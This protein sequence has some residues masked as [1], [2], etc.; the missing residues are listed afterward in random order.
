MV[1]RQNPRR[2]RT[3]AKTAEIL[4]KEGGSFADPH[5]ILERASNDDLD[6]YDPEELAVVARHAREEIDAFDGGESRITVRSRD[7]L[8]IGGE[9]VS[10]VSV[11]GRDMPFLFDSIMAEVTTGHRD[12]PLAIHPI[13]T[14]DA[15]GTP[16]RAEAG[17][18]RKHISH[19]QIH[20]PEIGETAAERLVERL[21]GVLDQVHAAVDDWAAMLE[22]LDET[23]TGLADHASEDGSERGEA[24]AFLDWLRDDNFIF[25]GMR[26][27][28]YVTDPDGAH[29]ERESDSGLGILAD[30]DIRV[31][32]RGAD[33]VTTTPEI[34]AFLEGSGLLIVTKANARSVVHRRAYMDY[35]G[36]KRFDGDG[37]LSGELRVVGLFTST[38]YTRPLDEIPL[39]RTKAKAVIERFHFDPHAHSGKVL[40][41]TLAAYPRDELF[42]IDTDLLAAFCEQINELGERPRVRVLPRIDHF[43]RFVSV[44]VFVPRERYD[45]DVRGRIGTCLATA[46]GGHVSAFYPAFPEGAVARVH[47]IIG[48]HDGATPDVSQAHLEREVRT[49]VTGWD[50]RFESLRPTGSAR[51][52]VDDAYREVFTPEEAVAD[53]PLISAATDG[54][55]IHLAFHRRRNDVE[56]GLS[57]K[58]FHTGEAL[59]LSRRVPLLENLGFDVV[60]ER[61]FDMTVEDDGEGRAVVL[62]DMQL[63]TMDGEPVD[64]GASETALEEAFL[65]IWAGR[66]DND[67]FN[68]L[69]VDAGLD[70]RKAS[71]LR[72]YARYL[73]Q[74][75]IT[76][77]QSYMAGALDRYP[78]AA[79]DIFRLF[80]NR[81]DPALSERQRSSRDRAIGERIDG[82]LAKVPSLDDDRIL[83]RFVN[84]V[85]ASL[86]TNYFQTGADGESPAMLAFKLDPQALEDLPQP[87]PYREI[88][89]Y[90]AEV[91]GVHLRFGPIARGGIRWSDRAE[92]YRTEV[93]GL[94]KA[95]QVKNAVI[96]PVGAKG[97][98]YP[99]QL[100]TGDRDAI[101]QAGK[102]A[103][104]TYITTLLSITD[105]IS[106]QEIVPPAD[107]VCHEGDDPYFVVAA[108]KGTATFSD[109]ANAI[110]Q[111]HDFWLDDAFASGGSAGYDHKAMA[112]T[113]RGA[114]EA[115]KRHFREM[116]VDIQTTPF[117]VAGVGDMSGDVF[118]NGM[119]LSQQI[120]LVAAFDHRDIF[121]D[122]DPNPATSFEE[123]KR[124]FELGRSSWQDYDKRKLSKGGTIVSRSQK[125][126]EL[127]SE[128]AA[129]IGLDGTTATPPEIM[130]AILRAPVDLLWFGGIGTYVK[131]DQQS[132]AEVGDR[133]NDA[134]RISAREVGA[135]VVGEG[136]NLGVT[137]RGRI[138]YAL[139]GG[140]I[141]SDAIDNSA[142]VNTSDVEVNI[143]IALAAA[144]REGRLDREKR[145]RLLKTMTHEV[146]DLVLAN[147][148]QQTLAISLTAR[149]GTENGD[150]LSGLMAHLERDNR[151]DRALELLPDDTAMSERYAADQPLTRP[152]IGV[153]LSYA[154]IVLFD[155]LCASDLPDDAYFAA[156]LMDYFPQKMCGPHRRDIENH[157]LRREIVATMLAN[158]AINR[159]RP[160][161]VTQMGEATGALPASVVR[162]YV[163]V[164]DG[165]D[166]HAV[167]A[168]IDALDAKVHG[169]VQNAMYA[170]VTEVVRSLTSWA[171]KSAAYRGDLAAG[172]DALGKAIAAL[173]PKLE[174]LMPDFL[175]DDMEAR[176]ATF[177]EAGVPEATADAVARLRAVGFIPE[178][179]QIAERTGTTL[180]KTAEVYFRVT[181]T[182]RIARIA[183]A[184]RRI[185][186][187]D[188]FEKLALARSL[189]EIAAA[190]RAITAASLTDHAKA[191]APLASWIEA[192]ETR[193][194]RARGQVTGLTEGGEI[195][196]AKLTVAAGLM[197][198]LARAD[199]L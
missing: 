191:K 198:D 38:A 152:E 98:F 109:T 26:A 149:L 65:A 197:R 114:W 69:I 184:A 196:L 5:V 145:N 110:S 107:T 111:A 64:L 17:D 9:P 125:S 186:T 188:R 123:R 97:G 130:S 4:E 15:D 129:A 194:E 84:A 127:S 176:R 89:V 167:Y 10:I 51:L 180:K 30:P 70:A 134:I 82:A 47:F 159:G 48:R 146:A 128:A 148:Y 181:E 183:D 171:L 162:A 122:P 24:I 39:L 174:G 6:R 50:D 13:L 12:I 19:I 61:T 173:K 56:D 36:I 150:E 41:N 144:M 44:L 100:P 31:L 170:E 153:L 53:L 115:V 76:Y 21:T 94:V 157:R 79:A 40:A 55:P 165:L 33:S 132:N 101:F 27:Y 143:K 3:I 172:V 18:R 113:A 45:S 105:T 34:L 71:V 108:D 25:L 161:F 147:N 63:R 75:G 7:G 77:S 87:R 62:H 169:D 187:S 141:N 195:T 57:L 156:T 73:R 20:L 32:R 11:T 91:E 93:L 112:I 131:G 95:Q 68:R 29:V 96:V 133:T 154:K 190:C 126:I 54:Q 192:H 2:A 124:V 102:H 117:T 88:F 135:K 103:Y 74:C 35:V 160:G 142:G 168:A 120:R 158:D 139:A 78:Q 164:R 72:A 22:K 189:D 66:F 177:T 193:I 151:L 42:Q 58:I 199:S 116:D 43:D 52:V 155:E 179:M 118:G 16:L 178:I 163:L 92:D 60:N 49:I 86:R 166:L 83:R 106:G 140:R 104:E 37:T 81:F 67:A 28:T 8:A 1:V 121:I 137:Q 90:G 119:L 85:R 175:V 80:E 185:A 99:K 14:R 59:A 138:D 136:A 46:Y 182:F 23:R